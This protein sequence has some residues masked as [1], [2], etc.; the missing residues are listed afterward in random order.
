MT[1]S[2][3]PLTKTFD[4]ESPFP[5]EGGGSLPKVQVAYRTWGHPSNRAILVCH[6]LTGSADVDQW[7][8]GLMG[9]G[10]VLDP[11]RH[12]IV[13]SNVLG[14]CYGTTGPSC[15]RPSTHEPWSADFPRVSVRDMVHLQ[16]KLLDHLGVEALDLVLGGSLGGMQV[17]EWAALY[18]DR[19][20]AIAPIAAP[21]AQGAWAIALAEAGRQAIEADG[22][23]QGGY[24]PRGEGPQ[25]GLAA[26]RTL[27]LISYRSPQSF[28]QR[29][30]R[31]LQG[32]TFA[33]ESYLRYQGE[34]FHRRFDPNTYLLLGEA[35]NSHDLGR[36]R[37]GVEQC[38]RAL[39]IPALVVSIDS[40]LLYP[41][42]EQ[43]EI[44][45]YLPQAQWVTVNSVHGH[46]AFLIETPTLNHHLLTFL[47]NTL[48][49][50]LWE[51]AV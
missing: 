42:E 24:Y 38:L 20:R 50:S 16:A 3:S 2:I 6:A 32:E 17:L 27:A 37:G 21:A 44:V 45:R 43:E 10:K 26:A 25:E 22:Q 47:E 1:L 51:Q 36:H 7:W 34:R 11:E 4:L 14:S 39:D 8:E 41:K 9:P 23:W 29:F 33:M 5:L 13:C 30:G 15:R 31:E 46:D 35:M 12:Y 48:R 40:D 18:P 19:V 28:A 49:H